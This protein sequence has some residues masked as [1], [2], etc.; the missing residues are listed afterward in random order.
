MASFNT[1]SPFEVAPR[2]I[3]KKNYYT[4]VPPQRSLIHIPLASSATK[5]STFRPHVVSFAF[6]QTFLSLVIYMIDIKSRKSHA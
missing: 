1:N 3:N 5:S 4:F 6:S 2:P